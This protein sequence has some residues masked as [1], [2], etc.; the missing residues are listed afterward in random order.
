M[1]HGPSSAPGTA[2]KQCGSAWS[3]GAWLLRWESHRRGSTFKRADTRRTSLIRMYSEKGLR[4]VT[5]KPSRAARARFFLRVEQSGTAFVDRQTLPLF[6]L[7]MVMDAE[8]L[9]ADARWEAS[10]QH[11]K[12]TSED[13]R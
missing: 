8:M 10:K 11:V 3:A 6:P 2:S 13:K 5:D 1:S 9:E 4:S 7:V 12:C